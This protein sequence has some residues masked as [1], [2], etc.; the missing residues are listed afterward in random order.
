MARKHRWF[1]V[2][3]FVVTVLLIGTLATGWNVVLVSN[4]HKFLELAG[5]VS[6]KE[7]EGAAPWFGITLGSLGFLAALGGLVLF[8]VK[9]L[10]EMRLN[11]LQSEFIATVSHELKT[12][13][14]TLEL[15]S[16]LLRDRQPAT[17]IT[18]D[19]RSRLW[20]SHSADLSR[21]RE[22]V[23]CLLEA[24]RWQGG[25]VRAAKERIHLGEWIGKATDRWNLA[26][27]P[28]A[29]LEVRAAGLDDW[30]EADPRLLNLL[31]DSLLDNARKFAKE[32]PAVE[33]LA[34]VSP[35]D[36]PRSRPRWKVEVRDRG[37]GFDPSD[38]KK[39]FQR[40]FRAR[41]SAPHAIPGTGLGLY[42]ASSAG[43]AM[44]IRVRGS[45]VGRGQGAVFT[46]EGSCARR[47]ERLAQP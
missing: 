31:F 33:I 5:T 23:E 8:F 46:L 11:Q 26:L 32:R 15:T 10:R 28:G 25:G 19:E 35:P 12:P 41:T 39:I 9:L 21:L 27:G 1:W 38:S 40:F 45:S 14:T 4:Y 47:T 30:I 3:L 17:P 42:L 20:A 18:R 13:L 16:S 36:S 22:Q 24:A 7:L 29:T 2:L 6:R 34:Q 37:W 43:K 44:G